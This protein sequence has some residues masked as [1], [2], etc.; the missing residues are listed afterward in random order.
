[1]VKKRLLLLFFLFICMHVHGQ[2]L[3]K[4][5]GNVIELSSSKAVKQ[6]TV[7][8]FKIADS[9]QPK[10]VRTISSEELEIDSLTIGVYRLTV[11]HV[12]FS[13]KIIDSIRITEERLFVNLGDIALRKTDGTLEDVVIY[14]EKPI[15]EQ[16]DGNII[17]NVAETPQG[18]SSNA[19]ELLKTTPLVTIDADGKVLLKGKEVKVLVDE[20]PVELN[21]KQL[22]EMLES[23]PGSFIEKIEVLNNPPPQFANERGG[24]INIVSKKGKAGGTLR[25]S[26]YY[27]TRGELGSNLAAGYK[28]NKYSLNLHASISKNNFDGS[29]FSLRNNIYKDSTNNFNTISN[30]NSNSLRPNI[31]LNADYD[32]NKQHSINFSANY[33]TNSALNNTVNNFVN[34]NKDDVVFRISDRDIASDVDNRNV[35]VNSTYT[36]K[37]K[38]KTTII[39]NTV[40]ASFANN[41][42]ERIFFQ[43]FFNGNGSFTGIDST[44]QQN[45]AVKQTN[46]SNMLNIDRILDSGKL[47]LNMGIQYAYI[48][49]ANDINFSFLKK[50]EAVMVNNPLL[51][52]Y[53]DFKQQITSSRLT[54]KYNTKQKWSVSVG[55]S[56]EYTAFDF[57]LPL[58]N[59]TASNNYWSWLPFSNIN[60]K[61]TDKANLTLSY[62]R[63]IQR[64]GVTETNPAVDYS[65]PYN[66]RFG[67]P[68]LLPSYADNFD[69]I[70]SKQKSKLSWNYSIGYSALQN[71][72]AAIRTLKQNGTTS[73]TY[74]NISNRKEYE[75]SIWAGYTLSKKTKVNIGLGYNYNVYSNF[76]KQRLRY[77]NGG[78]FTSNVNANYSFNAAWQANAAVTYNRF[79]SPQ[80]RVRANVSTTTS[81]QY[82]FFRKQCTVTFAAIDPFTQQRNTTF[83]T[84]QNFTLQ[85]FNST[86]TRNFK[87]TFSYSFFKKQKV[88][89]R[90]KVAE[91]KVRQ[92]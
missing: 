75:T 9:S 69:V 14:A 53:F 32:F 79:A 10:L 29:G 39:K 92:Q 21:A 35:N 1:M 54:L 42:N 38:Q 68:G 19:A 67:N 37:S 63:S 73:V 15:F 49:S 18:N 66:L 26:A 87:L 48:T 72:Y 56:L 7:N 43:A 58:S 13:K 44:Q 27:G 77:Q 3:G 81:V 30:N 24:V 57:M 25:T 71:I 80:G 50:P 45:N 41:N 51:S 22:Q 76:D 82:K 70:F 28:K 8:L 36:Y 5:I 61:F 4:I 83:T 78:S 90:A 20:K 88:K 86:Q 59:Q 52:N 62:K 60:Y 85:Q 64:P 11:T 55:T 46:F 91:K 47:V 12:G 31:K 89:A 6:A 65:D 74:E 17:Y 33:T 16:K 2:E 23:M 34:I 84:G 40:S